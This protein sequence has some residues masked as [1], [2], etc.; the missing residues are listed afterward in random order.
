VRDRTISPN[1]TVAYNNRLQEHLGIVVAISNTEN[2]HLFGKVPA[3][4]VEM[5]SHVAQREIGS[6]YRRPMIYSS[7]G[8]GLSLISS[9][10]ENLSERS[11]SGVATI[12]LYQWRIFI[13]HEDGEILLWPA[14][15]YD[16]VDDRVNNKKISSFLHKLEPQN[17]EDTSRLPQNCPAK[18]NLRL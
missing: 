16:A 10:P 18:S 9:D 17:C 4:M 2:A 3:N 1:I 15:V 8:F 5:L 7:E 13:S 11:P 14:Y 12:R 6:E